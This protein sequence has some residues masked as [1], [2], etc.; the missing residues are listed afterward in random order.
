MAC[1]YN[2]ELVLEEK[3]AVIEVVWGRGNIWRPSQD[4]A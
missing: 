4:H 3:E 1:M 2:E